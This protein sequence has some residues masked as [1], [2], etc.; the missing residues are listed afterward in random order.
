MVL[1]PENYRPLDEREKARCRS[2]FRTG[3]GHGG[4]VYEDRWET[5]RAKTFPC[6][7]CGHRTP[8]TWY[9]AQRFTSR[10]Q[11]T[12]MRR[13]RLCE[14]CCRH[15]A[16][17]RFLPEGALGRLP[18]IVWRRTPAGRGKRVLVPAKLLAATTGGGR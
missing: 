17:F 5:T 9:W 16:A 2:V 15:L 11:G 1:I 4:R 6:Q 18:P 7:N 13:C 10:K 12:G 8:V 3:G 14:N